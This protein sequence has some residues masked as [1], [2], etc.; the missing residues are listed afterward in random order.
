MVN[1]CSPDESLSNALHRRYYGLRWRGG[2]V[3]SRAFGRYRSAPLIA[4]PCSLQQESCIYRQRD[5]SDV[6][7]AL[8]AEE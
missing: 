4:K 2:R 7:C 5:S 6:P 8:A 3:S 1:A